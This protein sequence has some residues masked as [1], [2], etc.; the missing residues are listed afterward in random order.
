MEKAQQMIDRWRRLAFFLIV[1]YND[2]AEKPEVNGVF[3]RN[4]YGRGAKVKRLSYP[5]SV[6]RI[7]AE[8]TGERYMRPAAKQ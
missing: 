7:I 6:K 3:T 5:T 2:M 8:Q 4:Q 1:K